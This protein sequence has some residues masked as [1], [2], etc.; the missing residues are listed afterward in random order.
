MFKKLIAA[1]LGLFVAVAFAASVDANKATQAELESIK[2]VG[3]AI[4]TKIIDER[5]K[6]AFKDW[7]D[8]VV[9]VKGVGEGNAAKLSADGLT[10]NGSAFQPMAAAPAMKKDDMKADK[11]AAK[12]DA[13]AKKEE[14]KAEKA[15]MKADANMKAT[16]TAATPATPA[17]PAMPASAAMPAKKTV[18]AAP[19]SA[20]PASATMTAAKPMAP[21]PK[22][23]EPAK[24]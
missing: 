12:A 21:A 7:N 18:D 17:T 16:P 4:A 8:M 13:K 3:P 6:G 9:R 11:A 20:K 22:A 19:M 15:K 23:S 2:G 10:V 24:K 5:K 14:A 1:A